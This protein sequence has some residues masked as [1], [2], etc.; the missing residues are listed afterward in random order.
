MALQAFDVEGFRDSVER[1]LEIADGALA[2]LAETPPNINAFD[3]AYDELG[4]RYARLDAR[5]DRPFQFAVPVQTVNDLTAIYLTG[6][7]FL[8][9]R[10]QLAH[11]PNAH[12]KLVR[13]VKFLIYSLRVRDVPKILDAV[14]GSPA[15]KLGRNPERDALIVTLRDRDRLEW[16]EIVAKIN[17]RKRPS[18]TPLGNRQHAQIAYKREKSR[19]KTSAA[20]DRTGRTHWKGV[21]PQIGSVVRLKAGGPLMIVSDP[22]LPNP[23]C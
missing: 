15:Q 4:M 20:G 9:S 11:L 7:S 17:S 3:A 13:G 14:E 12:D 23:E 22:E 6:R 21:D 5:I 18:F 19:Q 2:Y 8:L 10:G 1:C 16:K